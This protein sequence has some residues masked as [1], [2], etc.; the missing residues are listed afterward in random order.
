MLSAQQI[1]ALSDKALVGMFAEL[2]SNE[3]SR[4]YTFTCFLMPE[5]C[6]QSFSSF[7]NENKAKIMM[8]THLLNHLEEL[9]TKGTF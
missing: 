5:Q 3:L 6:S 2:H 8:K 7:G 1:R 9:Q 4:N